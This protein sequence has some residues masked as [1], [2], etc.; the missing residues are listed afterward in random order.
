MKKHLLTLLLKRRFYLGNFRLPL[1]AYVIATCIEKYTQTVSF[2]NVFHNNFMFFSQKETLM[3]HRKLSDRFSLKSFA[4]SL[5]VIIIFL[6]DLWRIKT[7]IIS[8]HNQ[9]SN[10]EKKVRT[11]NLFIILNPL[12]LF[13]CYSSKMQLRAVCWVPITSINNKTKSWKMTKSSM[14]CVFS[15]FVFKKKIWGMWLVHEDL[16]IYF[17]RNKTLG[18][19]GKLYWITA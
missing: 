4:L 15:F 12:H 1:V 19:L 8:K 2:S 11:S 14:R 17:V 10:S 3:T 6:M 5:E 7:Q 18:Y 9:S 16:A 13:L